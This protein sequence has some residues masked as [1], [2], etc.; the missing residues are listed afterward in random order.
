M[1]TGAGRPRD[2][3]IDTA[4]VEAATESIMRDGFPAVTIDGI[5]RRAGTTKPAFYRRFASIGDMIPAILAAR[6]ALSANIDEGSLRDDL[7]AFQ[8]EQALIFDD[9]LVRQ[10]MAGWLAYLSSR[11]GDAEVFISGFLGP[12]LESLSAILVRGD[13]RGEIETPRDPRAVL[14]VLVGPLLLRSVVPGFEAIDGVVVERTV[15]TALVYVGARE[16]ARS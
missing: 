9:E 5:V 16:L 13:L 10:A 2:R 7:L 11:R 4:L 8:R 3:R 14:D 6:F 1:T 12:R 15:E